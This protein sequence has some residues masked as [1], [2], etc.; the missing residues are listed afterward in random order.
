MQVVVGVTTRMIER[1]NKATEKVGVSSRARVQEGNRTFLTAL[2]VAKRKWFK[3][4]Y[5]YMTSPSRLCESDDSFPSTYTRVKS[6]KGA[7]PI[8][9]LKKPIQFPKGTVGMIVFQGPSGTAEGVFSMHASQRILRIPCLSRL[10]GLSKKLT[11]SRRMP[12]QSRQQAFR[13][14]LMPKLPFTASTAHLLGRDE[15]SFNT[16]SS[17]CRAQICMLF[18]VSCTSS[19]QLIRQRDDTK[20]E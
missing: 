17:T 1:V 19:D 11:K 4:I 20:Q 6:T 18:R 15:R 3:S 14:F 16:L 12:R 5:P 13:P 10:P 9:L 2:R 7:S 8:H